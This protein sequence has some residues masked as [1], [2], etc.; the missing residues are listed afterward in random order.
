M[1]HS[2]EEY[3]SHVFIAPLLH[4]NTEEYSSAS[5]ADALVV[6]F[7][8]QFWTLVKPCHVM[9][10][11]VTCTLGVKMAIVQPKIVH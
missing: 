5:Y 8:K 11:L 3:V 9:S 2:A 4:Y 7:V 6:L 10:C 1:S